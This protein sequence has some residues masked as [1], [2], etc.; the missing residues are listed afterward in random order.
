M[1]SEPV[2]LRA[3]TVQEREN[4][5]YV[6]LG[7]KSTTPIS[8]VIVDDQL[9][10]FPGGG[11]TIFLDDVTFSPPSPQLFIG[12]IVNS[13]EDL[14]AGG[15]LKAAQTNGLIKKLEEAIKKLDMGNVTPA[16]LLDVT[17]PLL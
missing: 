15:V 10:P 2:L 16:M 3:T 17:S 4:F 1:V 5:T 13:V 14:V 8:T 12:L 6:F 9:P 7:L 11:S